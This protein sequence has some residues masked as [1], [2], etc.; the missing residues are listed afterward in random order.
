MSEQALDLRRSVQNVRR[1]KT[2]VVIA[3]A[4]GILLGT[5][6]AVLRPPMLTSTA[7][8]LLPQAASAQNAGT[9][10]TSG[11]TSFI[12]TQVVIAGSAPVLSGALPHASPAGSVAELRNEVQVQAVTDSILSISATART[13]AQAEATASAVANSYIAYV[14]SGNI[15]GGPVPAYILQPATNATGTSP[16]THLLVG[17]LVGA[18]VGALIGIIVALVIS[19]GDRRLRLCDEISASIGLPV[20][21]S[22]SVAHPTDAASWTMLL[23]NYQ[24]GAVPA[25]RLYQVLQQLGMADVSMRNGGAGSG[26]SLG[27]I[28]LSSDPG[29][30]A[31]GPQ[32]AVFAASRG[33]PTALLI[34]PQQNAAVTASLRTACAVPPPASSRR[35]SHL[36]V[37]VSDDGDIDG[38]QA[39]RLTVVVS[40]VDGR[41]SKA[42]ETPRT[43]ATVLG[44]SAGAATA[45]QLARFVS[46]AAADGR[47][48]AG[49]LVADPEPTDHTSG[50]VPPVIRLGA[51]QPAP[52][53]DG[54][55]NGGQKLHDPDQTIVFTTRIGPP[56]PSTEIRR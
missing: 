55:G 51:A 33:I 46:G 6:Y 12:A 15:L 26:L 22:L 35:P 30:L 41:P 54:H 23:E 37:M 31:L 20:L 34:G 53:L 2:L 25:L 7:L 39:G 43:T 49:I 29:A 38:Q 19:R 44:V 32:L 18:I 40:V 50:R 47:D 36:R 45:D 1:H 9:T 48:I 52:S 14:R 5:A 28:S 3:I 21:A 16:I 56:D 8:V 13:A 17:I 27:V 11:P 10:A 42:A 24:P 4:L